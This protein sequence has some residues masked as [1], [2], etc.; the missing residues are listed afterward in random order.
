MDKW[1]WEPIKWN[2][3]INKDSMFD[4]EKVESTANKVMVAIDGNRGGGWSTRWTICPMDYEV[5]ILFKLLLAEGSDDVLMNTIYEL[6]CSKGVVSIEDGKGITL[7]DIRELDIKLEYVNDGDEFQIGNFW[8]SD[9]CGGVWEDHIWE[10]IDI[11]DK[12]GG[13]S[14]GMMFMTMDEKYGLITVD[15]SPAKRYKAIKEAVN[16]Y[17]HTI[18]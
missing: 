2:G 3:I 17:K 7:D 14:L 9:G 6:C 12:F 8:I 16:G 13:G 1:K 11:F 4:A 15:S 10:K 5:N 18:R